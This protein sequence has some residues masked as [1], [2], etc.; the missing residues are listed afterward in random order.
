M[1]GPAYSCPPIAKRTG[2]TRQIVLMLISR[3]VP[4]C[5]TYAAK[6]PVSI[7]RRS[8]AQVG[9]KIAHAPSQTFA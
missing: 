8:S 6:I 9:A 7:V 3:V 5:T 2:A 1:T 4:L